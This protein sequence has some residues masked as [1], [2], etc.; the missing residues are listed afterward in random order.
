MEKMA[1]LDNLAWV[2]HFLMN[3]ELSR[4]AGD[5]SRWE[6]VLKRLNLLNNL[7]NANSIFEKEVIEKPE[8]KDHE[9]IIYVSSVLHDMCDKKYMNQQEGIL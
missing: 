1:S 4:P 8:I 2:F 5:I 3:L 7:L 6:K 9:K